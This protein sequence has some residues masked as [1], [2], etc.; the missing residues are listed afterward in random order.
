MR[1]RLSVVTLLAL[2][3]VALPASASA[4][5]PHVIQRG[6]TL[7]SV[8]AVDGLSVSALAAANG[9]SVNSQLVA[10]QILQIPPRGVTPKTVGTAVQPTTTV[11]PVSTQST[12]APARGRFA[13]PIAT[14]ERV[15][16]SEIADIANANGVPASFA[17]AIAWQESGWNN[18]EISDVGAVG[19]MQI[20]PSTW[21]WIDRYLTPGSPLGTASAAENVRGGVLLLHQLLAATGD[22]YALTAAGYFQGLASVRRYGMYRSTRRYV[23]DV[24]ALQQRLAG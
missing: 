17:E 7:T 21:R 14:A 8:A 11:R 2:V 19:V 5:Y 20:V 16:G 12:T 10:G 6:E 4:N 22:S 23:A 15:P 24:L 3:S 18:A 13:A 1:I 9:M